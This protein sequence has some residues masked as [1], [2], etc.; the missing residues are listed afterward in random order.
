MQRKEKFHQLRKVVL[1]YSVVLEYSYDFPDTLSS[2]GELNRKPEF[3]F[4]KMILVTLKNSKYRM[5]IYVKF[6]SATDANSIQATRIH[7]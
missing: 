3:K 1:L 5:K 4:I 2:K 6:T 7:Q